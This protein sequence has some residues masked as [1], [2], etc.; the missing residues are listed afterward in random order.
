MMVKKNNPFNEETYFEREKVKMDFAQVGQMIIKDLNDTSAGQQLTR[1]YAKSDVER[2]LATPSRYAK[3]LGAMSKA[4]YYA[5]P[6]YKRLIHYFADMPRMD[7]VVEPYGLDLSKSFNEKSFKTGYQRAVDLTDLINVKH[8][9]KKALRSAWIQDTFYGYEYMAKD[10]YFI[11][12]LP[13]EFCQISSVEDGVYNIGFNFQYFDRNP[14]QVELYPPEFK[15]MYNKFKS[16]SEGQWQEL[17]VRKTVVIKI[18]EAEV[19]DIPPFVG[20]F[21]SI[22][23]IE[24]YKALKLAKETMSNYKFI[25]QKIPIRDKSERNNDFLIDLT[26]VSMFHN[27][28]AN[29]LPDGV[30]LITTP[31]E[32]DT[33]NFAKDKSEQ[34]NVQEAEREL[35]SSAGTSSLLFNGDSSANANLA[36]SIIVDEAEVFTLLRQVERFINRKM[37]WEV[38]GT[39]KFRI[40]ILDTTEQNWKEVAEQYLKS[41]QFGMP[42]KMLLGASLGLTPSAMVNMAYLENVVLDLT[43]MLVPL[44]SAHTQTGDENTSDEG[45]RPESKEDELSEKGEEQKARGDNENRE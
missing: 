40:K 9:F 31:F 25:V 20:I 4:L 22:Y 28:T 14:T 23:D 32:V 11:K 19:F 34:D 38:K 37:K 29:T 17:D 10:S 16:G 41:A 15:S 13:F 18:N 42:V 5:S 35:Y 43:N 26:N 36:K 24:N 3:E 39:Y 12:E 1:S 33:I 21:R 6:H 2:F 30:G 27:K 7:F 8:E 44:T 45:G